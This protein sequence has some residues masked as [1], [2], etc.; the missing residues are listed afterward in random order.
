MSRRCEPV[1]N[2]GNHL[3]WWKW[4]N[5][6]FYEISTIRYFFLKSR[7]AI[8]GDSR[9]GIHVPPG[10]SEP[11]R[12]VDPCFR[13]FCINSSAHIIRIIAYSSSFSTF[14]KFTVSTY[15]DSAF[16][17]YFYGF[18]CP[19]FG[20]PMVEYFVNF[21]NVGMLITKSKKRPMKG[22]KTTANNCSN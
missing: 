5:K 22:K 1:H 7:C 21:V 15:F 11:S 16:F 9:L 6:C 14:L 20:F 10:T 4:T 2:N 19:N 3:F 18:R 8:L 12:S 13:T 17:S